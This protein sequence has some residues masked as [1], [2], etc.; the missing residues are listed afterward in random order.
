MKLID[1]NLRKCGETGK[2]SGGAPRMIYKLEPHIMMVRIHPL[3]M[4]IDDSHL[5]LLSP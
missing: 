5:N 1:L 2:R 3:P 4:G